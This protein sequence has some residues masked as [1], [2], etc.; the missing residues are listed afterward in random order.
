MAKIWVEVCLISAR[1]LRRTSS[2]WKLQWFAV[3]WI[4]P[5]NKYCTNIH[6]SGNSNPVWKTK[7]AALLDDSNF[8]DAA[9]HVQV[10]SREP[11]FLRETLQGAATVV[12]KEFLANY[13][14]DSSRQKGKQVGSYQLRKK[15]SSKPQ[16]F[17]DVSIHISEDRG[18]PSSYRGD[19]GGL[20]LMDHGNDIASSS[21]SGGGAGQAAY[22]SDLPLAPPRGPQNQFSDYA[23]VNPMPY[24]PKHPN[25]S[26]GGFGPPAAGGTSY[27]PPRTP[28]PPPPPSN[29][30]YVPTFLP[31]S[32]YINMPSSLAAPRRGGMT[33]SS[34][35][36]VGA[37]ALAAGAVIFGDDF[38]SGFSIPSSLPDPSLT[39][40]TDPPF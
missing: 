5:N 7:F 22:P 25:Q 11:L 3:G 38:M 23:H 19:E 37:G 8:H 33:P 13:S 1:G 20:A 28:P 24:P 27:N 36:G 10:Y 32:D 4:D 2:L 29:V 21:G 12:L 15:S 39:I 34:A 9:L 40:S 31:N 17:I 6:P 35:M 26:T 18:E 14:S 16:G 30:G